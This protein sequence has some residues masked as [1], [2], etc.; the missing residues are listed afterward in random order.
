MIAQKIINSICRHLKQTKYTNEKPPIT[1]NF[2]K[3]KN[4]TIVGKYVFVVA[5]G[6]GAATNQ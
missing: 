5:V 6:G 4:M 1:D 2:T 3:C